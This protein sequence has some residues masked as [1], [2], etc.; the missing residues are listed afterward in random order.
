MPRLRNSPSVSTSFAAAPRLSQLLPRIVS[1]SLEAP[2]RYCASMRRP[3][4]FTYA[5]FAPPTRPSTSRDS[6]PKLFTLISIITGTSSRSNS[7]RSVC[8][9]NCSGTKRYARPRARAIC[10]SSVN[11]FSRTAFAVAPTISRI[12]HPPPRVFSSVHRKMTTCK[13]RPIK[14]DALPAIL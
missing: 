8:I 12:D 1:P 4:S 3:L 2:S 9:V 7:A 10:A 11:I 5:S 6:E 13:R 14:I